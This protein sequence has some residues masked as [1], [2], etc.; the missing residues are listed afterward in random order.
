MIYE[1]KWS[2]KRDCGAGQFVMGERGE[3]GYL[4]MRK[5][6]VLDV[7]T[8]VSQDGYCVPLDSYFRIGG[9]L[10]IL[11]HES[12]KRSNSRFGLTHLQRLWASGYLKRLYK[13]INKEIDKKETFINRSVLHNT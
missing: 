11:G 5:D 7:L 6:G 8:I 13:K 12:Q 2:K 1:T 9:K 4:E 10:L 3:I